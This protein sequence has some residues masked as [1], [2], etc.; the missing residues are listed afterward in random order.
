MSDTSRLTRA[1]FLR[2]VAGGGAAL[3]MSMPGLAAKRAMRT[4]PIP[5][6]GEQL[7]V[8]GLG[9]SRAFDVDREP[10]GWAARMEV[11]RTHIEGGGKVIDSSPMYGRAESVV[12]DMLKSLG[13][14]DR[15]FIA[16]KVWTE[17]RQDGIDQMEESLRLFHTD[18]IELMQVHNLVDT[19]VHLKTLRKW[20]DEGR[21]RYIGITHWNAPALDDLIDVVKREPLDFVQMAY[22]LGEREAE[23]HLMPLLHDKGVAMLV[24]RP[25]QRGSLFRRV[26]GKKLPAWAAEFDCESW[27][28]MFLKF[29][30]SH[31][32]AT[33]VIPATRKP[34]HM[35]D[36]LGAGY[37]RLPDAAQ[38]KRIAAFWE[39]V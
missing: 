16:T 6:S 39:G 20:K 36:N 34:K 12:G 37:G 14:R 35:R 3:T 29:I 5:K 15:A 13:L 23:R 28:Q 17:G 1:E 26:R 22:S 31:P 27:G 24:N 8:I 4:K 21:V 11:I 30:L 38:R 18:R 32:A 7:P 9:T 33:C 25:Y 2:L 10:V 19:S